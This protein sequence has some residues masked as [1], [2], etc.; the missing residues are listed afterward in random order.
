[1]SLAVYNPVSGE[2]HNMTLFYLTPTGFSF[3]GTILLYVALSYIPPVRKY[4]LN[5][6]K[7][8]KNNI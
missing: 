8:I 6:R 4:L 3:I 1:M 5:D 2:I 7:D